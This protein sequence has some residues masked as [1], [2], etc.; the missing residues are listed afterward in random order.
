MTQQ[1]FITKVAKLVQKYAPQ[2]DIRVHSPIIAQAILESASGTSNKVVKKDE[3]GNVVEWRHNYLGLKWRN[4]R[5]A[6]SNDYFE[7]ITSEQ[8]KDGQYITITSKFCKFKSL[9]DCILG[10]FQWTNI[11]NY[12]NLKGITDPET[13]LKNIKADGYATSHGYVENV[14]NVIKKYNLTQ[15]DNKRGGNSMSNSP[16]V[17]CRVMSPNH[18]GKRTK[19]LCRITPHCVVGELSAESI[20]GCFT[21]PSRKAS[22]QYGIGTE[23]RVCL[24]VDEDKRSWCSSSNDNDQQAI[25]IECASS[26]TAPYTMNSKVYAKLIEL[27]VDICR[28]NGKTKLLWFGDKNKS[29]SYEPADDEMVITVHRWFANKSCPGDWLYSRLGDLANK[30]TAQLNEGTQTPTTPDSDKVNNSFPA[31]P[32]AVQVLIDD[33]WIRKTPEVKK[34]EVKYTKKGVFTIVEVQDGWGLLKSYQK[35]RNGWIW[36]GNPEYVTIGKATNTSKPSTSKV[37]YT[38]QVT[39][40]DLNIRKTPEYTSTNKTGKSTGKGSFTIVEEKQG[41]IDSK[42]TMGTWGLLKS[43]QKNRNGWICLSLDCVVKK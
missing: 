39:V 20:G 10:Y 24:I 31:V 19:K 28:R 33:L 22:C 26:K 30:V 40:S 43:Y 27:C 8:K 29:L 14:M 23:G 16:L 34:N 9:E 21:S 3:N 5:C 13:Y 4:N 18:S 2:F 36:L 32:F 17:D 38:V 1:E 15:Y 41:T 35:N 42:G 12:A 7:E 37:P 25:T 6:V 11:A